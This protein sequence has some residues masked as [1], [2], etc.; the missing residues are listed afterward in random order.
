MPPKK[1]PKPFVYFD[2]LSVW[3]KFFIGV[4]SAITLFVVWSFENAPGNGGL[5]FMY[6]TCTHSFICF[7]LYIRLRN[8]RY[9]LIWLFFGLLHVVFFFMFWFVNGFL[10]PSLLLT[11]FLLGLYQLMRFW[12]LETQRR[13]FVYPAR[14]GKTGWFENKKV[15]PLDYLIAFILIIACYGLNIFAASL[16]PGR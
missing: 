2:Q 12:S 14:N 1:E 16:T 5:L 6:G 4:Y 11:V 15:T 13:E 10:M 8:F 9:Y 3:D 7:F